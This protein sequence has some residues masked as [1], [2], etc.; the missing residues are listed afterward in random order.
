MQLQPLM[1]MGHTI[2]L[3]LLPSR[4]G[5]QCWVKGKFPLCTWGTTLRVLTWGYPEIGQ[6]AEGPC[7]SGQDSQ[8][9]GLQNDCH[10]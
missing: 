2:F 1:I 5:K 3:P 7:P 9:A 6:N 8:I 4:L 10:T